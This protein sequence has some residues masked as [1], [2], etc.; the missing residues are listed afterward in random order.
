MKNLRVI[1]TLDD[2]PE[3]AVYYSPEYK[4]LGNYHI[5]WYRLYDS[6]CN[7]IEDVD[8]K[9][10]SAIEGL[11]RIIKKSDIEKSKIFL[12]AYMLE[13]FNDDYMFV[14]KTDDTGKA[15]SIIASTFAGY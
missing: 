7:T 5:H 10:T 12:S 1:K 2:L 9:Y 14:N 6:H 3:N 13:H 8:V 11:R 15:L 4:R